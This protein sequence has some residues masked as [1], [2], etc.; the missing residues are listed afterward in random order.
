MNPSATPN[1]MSIWSA[2][3]HMH[4]ERDIPLPVDLMASVQL[5]LDAW[6]DVEDIV[7]PALMIFEM[8]PDFLDSQVLPM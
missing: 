8:G 1:L 3:G 2:A 4:S 5:D 6:Y 7:D